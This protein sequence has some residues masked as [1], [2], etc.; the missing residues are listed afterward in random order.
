MC[1]RCHTGKADHSGESVGEPRHPLVIVIAF[2]DDRGY[3]KY[4]GGMPRRKAAAF[5]WRFAAIEERIIERGIG[6]HLRRP[7]SPCHCFH[8]KIDDGAVGVGFGAEQ[9]RA[10]LVIVMPDVASRQERSGNGD[11]FSGCDRRVKSVVHIVQVPPMR[12][13]VGHDV[14]IGNQQSGCATCDGERRQPMLALGQFDRERPDSFLIVEKICRQTPPRDLSFAGGV[15]RMFRV[16]RRFRRTVG[17][18]SDVILI[19]R[20]RPDWQAKQSRA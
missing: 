7:L 17:Q 16:M 1:A 12:S 8:G 9:R 5:E 10:Y 20:Q 3:R 13:E 18:I 6:R 15:S 2:G 4:T 11:D 14:G 19:L